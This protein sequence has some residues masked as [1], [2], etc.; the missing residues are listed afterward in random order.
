MRIENWAVITPV[1]DPYA[2]PET[3]SPSLRGQVYGH[4]RFDDGQWVTTSS[5]VGKNGKNEVITVSS[6][7]YELG[8]ADPQYEERFPGARDRLLNSLPNILDK[9]KEQGGWNNAIDVV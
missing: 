6:S 9:I 5:I 1:V 8:Q 2:A 7:A 3:I 4:P